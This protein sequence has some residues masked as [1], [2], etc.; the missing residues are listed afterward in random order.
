MN[1][2]D[3]RVRQ[4]LRT[5]NALVE[6]AAQLIR[7]RKT[8]T[9]AEVGDL[10]LVGRTTAYR[11]FPTLELLRAHAALWAVT[12][13]EQVEF[14]RTLDESASFEDRLTSVVSISDTSTVA[15]EAEYRA[16]LRISLEEGQEG[17]D[18]PRRSGARSTLVAEAL[19]GLQSQLDAKAFR[20]LCSAIS[21]FV[22]IEST[23]VLRD[24]CHLSAAD[25]RAVKLWA[26]GVLLKA[27]LEEAAAAPAKP[28]RAAEAAA[29][30]AAKTAKRRGKT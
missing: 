2:G 12:K 8:F 19:E 7:E 18:M 17:Q 22:G 16:M 24:V 27:G 25:A 26:A 9:V 6:V 13:A 3:G 5:R 14:E 21:L 4:K 10:A 20:R 23:V 29:P 11:Y 28:K 1:L 15:H 30:P